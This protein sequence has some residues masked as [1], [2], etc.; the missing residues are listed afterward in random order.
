MI[1]YF[2][3]IHVLIN[4]I[5]ILAI[6]DFGEEEIFSKLKLILIYNREEAKIVFLT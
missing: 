5:P 3:Y 6:K 4:K 2:V 1:S